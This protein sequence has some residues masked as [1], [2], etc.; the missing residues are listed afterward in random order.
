MDFKA[1]DI[2][3]FL[4]GEVV[5]NGDVK[6]TN[7]SKIEEGK[8]GT[9]A[10]LANMK[11]ENFIYSTGASVVLVNKSFVPKEKISTTLI[12]VD[13]A[14][15]AF[16]SLLDLYM[17]AKAS[18]KKGIEQPCFID[19]SVYLGKDIFIG[20]FSYISKNSKI[21][22]NSKLF[23]QVHIGENVTIGDDC[24][25]Y[26]GVKIYD[27]CIIGNGCILQAGVVIGSDGFGFAPQKDGTYKK[28]PQIGNVILEDNVEVGANSTVDCGT[29]GSTILRKGCKIDN[30][31]QI[32]HNCEIGENTAI[33]AQTGLAGT[34]K[35]GNNCRIGGQVGFA[36]HLSVGDNVMIGAQSGIAKS[37]KSNQILLGSP[38]LNIKDAIKSITVYKNL[39]QLRDEV[40][41]LQKE[42]KTLKKT[43]N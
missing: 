33:A 15:E 14:Y 26:S 41:Q 23:P 5:G 17:Q 35:I 16:A 6:V 39:P 37:L 18:V 30:L 7:V 27:D 24:I 1:T 2:A 38:T 43:D 40:I 12:K 42:I 25:I 19:E 20:A 11:Y 29:M 31:V 3:A 10:F 36:G 21:G 22:N 4:N 9:L 13:D 32:A 8:P 34:T 28:I